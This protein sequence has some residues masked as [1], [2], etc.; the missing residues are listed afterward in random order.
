MRTGPRDPEKISRAFLVADDH[1]TSHTDLPFS[2]MVMAPVMS[3]ER[4]LIIIGYVDYID[5]FR[6]RHRGGYA[7]SYS[8]DVDL[9]D[10]PSPEARAKRNNLVFV[11][12]AG[13]NYDRLRVPGEG[14]DWDEN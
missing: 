1:F 13:Y 4:Q 12:Q 3:G 10:Y 2:P 9:A 5:A 8:P 14:G 11:A 6:Q 7:R